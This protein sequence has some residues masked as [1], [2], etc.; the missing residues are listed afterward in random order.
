MWRP[1]SDRQMGAHRIRL[2]GVS[3]AC[4]VSAGA[5]AGIARP[6]F[7]PAWSYVPAATRAHLAKQLGGSLFLPARA[8]LFYRYRGGAR[9]SG[10]VLTVPFRNRVRIRRGLWRWTGQTFLWQV[11]KLPA[12]TAC[13]QWATWTQSF[14]LAGN[15]VYGGVGPGGGAVAW[16]C[17]TDRHGT[18]VLA[19]TNG[20]KLPAVG[21]GGVVASGLDVSHRL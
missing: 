12:G 18:H 20:G 11:R 13:R 5:F 17:V 16:R 10:G 1:Y 19:A 9:V 15:K 8:P 3:L 21:L 6:T 2:V 7:T 14:Q 4:L